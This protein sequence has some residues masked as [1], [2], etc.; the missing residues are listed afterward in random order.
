M[1]ASDNTDA[2]VGNNH[3]DHDGND[4][5]LITSF[6]DLDT[7]TVVNNLNGPLPINVI[8]SYVNKIKL[9]AKKKV[10]VMMIRILIRL[11]GMMMTMVLLE[12]MSL[13]MT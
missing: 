11:V 6:I 13:I 9:A 8:V 4:E 12:R 3:D 2:D 7:G 5:E 10:I 1:P